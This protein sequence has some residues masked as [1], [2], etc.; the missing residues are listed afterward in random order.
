M[1]V[2]PE[3]SRLVC[4]G[5]IVQ[6]GVSCGD[7]AL[8]HEG[9]SIRPVGTLLEE[10]VPVLREVVYQRHIRKL[11]IK[12]TYD[13]SGGEHSIVGQVVDNIDLEVVTDIP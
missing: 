11:L 13:G 1:A 12:I 10:T 8:V 3:C 9:R 4:R 7:R 2:I 6:E 5:E